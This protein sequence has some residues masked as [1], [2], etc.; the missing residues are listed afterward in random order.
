MAYSEH[1]WTGLFIK[2]LEDDYEYERRVG[3]GKVWQ[4]MEQAMY[5]IMS[6]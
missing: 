6:F 5:G 4:V 2:V 1:D 3:V